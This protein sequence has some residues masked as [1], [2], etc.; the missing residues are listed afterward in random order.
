MGLSLK[1]GYLTLVARNEVR[2]NRRN[3]GERSA[4]SLR[5]ARYVIQAKHSLLNFVIRNHEIVAMDHFGAAASIPEPIIT[6]GDELAFLIFSALPAVIS[7]R[8]RGRFRACPVPR[9]ITASPR[10][11]SPST[12]VTPTG[13]RLLPA[14]SAATA[15]ASMVSVPFGSSDPAIQRLRAGDGICRGR[16]PG[17]AAAIGDRSAADARPC[18]TR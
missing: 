13:S 17:A 9:T 15:P 10:S 4:P 3:D 1:I 6:S 5:I 7:L 2:G 11:K 16:E 12:L 18:R 14:R 8:G